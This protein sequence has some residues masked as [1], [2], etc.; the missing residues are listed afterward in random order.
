MK[1]KASGGIRD[2]ETAKNYI[3][4]GVSRIGTSS[5]ISIVKIK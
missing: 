5:G 2:Q 3:E 1:I 4:L